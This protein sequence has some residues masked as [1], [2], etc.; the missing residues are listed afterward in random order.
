[1]PHD[2]SLLLQPYPHELIKLRKST[3]LIQGG[4]KDDFSRVSIVVIKHHDKKQL[5]EEIDYLSY[6]S[7]PEAAKAGTWR[8]DM[9]QKP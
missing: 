4:K 6:I 1:M 2:R 7:L 9:K 8:K 3:Q 5:G